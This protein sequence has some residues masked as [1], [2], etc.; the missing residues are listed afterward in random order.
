VGVHINSHAM[1]YPHGKILKNLS[2]IEGLYYSRPFE[3]T[4]RRVLYFLTEKANPLR[5][6]IKKYLK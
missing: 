1:G 6:S 3:S 5:L 4:K 2:K